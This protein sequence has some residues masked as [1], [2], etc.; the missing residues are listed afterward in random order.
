MESTKTV[1]SQ[2]IASLE[3]QTV[4]TE[5][6]EDPVGTLIQDH[7]GALVE[8]HS[9]ESIAGSVTAMD[10]GLGAFR[11]S[12][13]FSNLTNLMENQGDAPVPPVSNTGAEADATQSGE[14][15]VAP[16]NSKKRNAP[17]VPEEC[18]QPKQKCTQRA[19]RLSST[20]KQPS[21]TTKN[22]FVVVEALV[23]SDAASAGPS[24][25][26]PSGTAGEEAAATAAAAAVAAALPSLP[27]ISDPPVVTGPPPEQAEEKPV[28]S[29]K[30][31]VVSSD[32]SV[33]SSN[34]GDS[35]FKSIAQQAVSNLIMNAGGTGAVPAEKATASTAK[36]D[37]SDD[38]S[39]SKVD[40]S[41][42][43]IKALTGNNWVA[44]CSGTATS[45]PAVTQPPVDPKNNN[46]V[47][48]QNL[49][50]DER[51]RQN[52]DRNREHARN[53][54]LRKKAYVEEL[55]RT[56]TELVAQRDA[57]DLEKRQTAQREAEQ[58]EVRFRVMEEFLKL[59]GRNESN[60]G[61]WAAILEEGFSLTVPVSSL[62]R[63]TTGG[64]V[65]GFEQKL[66]SVE[67][68]MA[69]SSVFSNFLQTLGVSG[70]GGVTMN[71]T[72]D[73]KNFFMDGCNAVLE[74]SASA[75]GG[76]AELQMKGTVRGKFS[77]ASNKLASAAVSYDCGA[78]AAQVQSKIATS[79]GDE[80]D[81]VAA[82]ADALLDSLNIDDVHLN[83]VV[84]SDV[85]VVIASN[86]AAS[87]IT[88]KAAESSDEYS[89]EATDTINDIKVDA[90]G[91]HV[92]MTTRRVHR[93]D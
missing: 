40:T 75:V 7:P 76:K 12:T 60:F 92:G 9:G 26:T 27:E 8:E 45:V 67:T 37:A 10:D 71:V 2:G 11:P 56:L 19:R 38:E 78:I 13:S 24:V 6:D 33:S 72:C 74:W 29:Q 4:K 63:K 66:N 90:P 23:R 85:S 51:A 18:P 65:S 52:R 62:C 14:I 58:R 34:N 20:K 5:L 17:T 80:I 47:R 36:D 89:T 53:T 35:Q 68:V 28:P 44:A 93:R 31:E 1:P 81:V 15:A 54:R 84:P 49:T 70:E 59:R 50:P 48:R 79:P 69:E 42:A 21:P 55:K 91:D 73:R 86:S 87:V 30:A 16:K 46:R 25:V 43:H 64:E 22:T 3:P 32:S 77:P 39:N 61:R 41:T 88:E 82:Q 57:V 83:V